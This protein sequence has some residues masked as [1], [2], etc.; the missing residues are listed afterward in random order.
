MWATRSF[1]LPRKCV[2]VYFPKLAGCRKNHGVTENKISLGHCAWSGHLCKRLGQGMY[3]DLIALLWPEKSCIAWKVPAS[4][5]AAWQGE[6]QGSTEIEEFYTLKM[7]PRTEE[8]D[9]GLASTCQIQTPDWDCLLP[10]SVAGEKL[11]R[12]RE[13]QAGLLYIFTCP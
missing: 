11:S 13:L 2:L 7:L 9:R 4:Q 6:G 8:A 3:L 5:Q 12:S 1:N 10:P